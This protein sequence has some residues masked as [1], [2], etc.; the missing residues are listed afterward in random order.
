MS[1]ENVSR[2]G[3][4]VWRLIGPAPLGTIFDMHAAYDAVVTAER[5]GTYTLELYGSGTSTGTSNF[6]IYDVSGV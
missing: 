6:R 1:F 3:N 5:T 2:S 4:M